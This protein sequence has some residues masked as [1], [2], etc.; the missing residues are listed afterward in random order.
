MQCLAKLNQRHRSVAL[1]PFWVENSAGFC[2]IFQGNPS[3]LLRFQSRKSRCEVGEETAVPEFTKGPGL[4]TIRGTHL[5]ECSLAFKKRILLQ[6][7]HLM[8]YEHCRLWIPTKRIQK[9]CWDHLSL[10]VAVFGIFI[11][12]I[13]Y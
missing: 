1:I 9:A 5:Y 6:Q 11:L 10:K 13:T 3:L 8:S 4:Q 7:L 12:D 2:S